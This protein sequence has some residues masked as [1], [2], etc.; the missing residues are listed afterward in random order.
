[1]N[2][3]YLQSQ[4]CLDRQ[5]LEKKEHSRIYEPI[6]ESRDYE[7]EQ[8]KMI[9]AKVQESMN[10]RSMQEAGFSEAGDGGAYVCVTARRC[11]EATGM[12]VQQVPAPRG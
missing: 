10:A 12:S 2:N 9:A 8:V 5:K 1:M 3:L 4:S 6:L 11:A 7:A